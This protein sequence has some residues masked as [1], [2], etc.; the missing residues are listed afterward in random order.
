MVRWALPFLAFA[1]IGGGAAARL[2]QS[3]PKPRATDQSDVRAPIANFDA[4][5]VVQVASDR[6]YDNAARKVEILRSNGHDA[7]VLWSTDYS[8]P[9]GPLTS[10]Y[11][12]TFVGPFPET[13]AGLQA[14][15]AALA[16]IPR[17]YGALVRTGIVR[18]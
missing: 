9:D 15:E 14:A 16:R 3:A 10:D 6:S 17:E 2:E 7:G 4:G 13:S 1:V 8:S 18:R 11:Y 5:T 12:V